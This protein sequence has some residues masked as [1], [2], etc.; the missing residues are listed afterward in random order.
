MGQGLDCPRPQ[1]SMAKKRALGRFTR[2]KY[3]SGGEPGSEPCKRGQTCTHHTTETPPLVAWVESLDSG[4]GI[5]ALIHV[6]DHFQ[7]GMR[8]IA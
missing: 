2:H 3:N 1:A 6:H 7:R 4:G 5:T 8:A